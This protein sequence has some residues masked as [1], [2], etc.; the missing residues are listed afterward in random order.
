MPFDALPELDGFEFHNPETTATVNPD[1][2]LDADLRLNRIP[3][4]R[5]LID[6]R[7]VDDMRKIIAPLPAAGVTCHI[8]LSGKASLWDLVPAVLEIAAPAIINELWIATLG[9]SNR[10]ATELFAYLDGGQVGRCHFICSHYF[11][12]TSESIYTPMETGMVKRG[13]R[14]LAMRNHSKLI[15][16]SLSDGCHIVGESSANLR[17]CKNVETLTLTH[18]RALFEFHTRWM[19]HIFMEAGHGG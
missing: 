3:A 1:V 13:Q 12:G 15:L 18:D 5:K 8:V 19:D 9:F 11:K 6:A 14:F 2:G 7:Q 16:M 4:A 17:S 10:N